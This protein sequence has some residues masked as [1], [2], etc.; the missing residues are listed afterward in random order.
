MVQALSST[1]T[2]DSEAQHEPLV[3]AA[4]HF[5]IPQKVLTTVHTYS[6]TSNETSSAHTSRHQHFDG[7]LVSNVS[8]KYPPVAAQRQPVHGESLCCTNNLVN[9]LSAHA[10]SMNT[11]DSCHVLRICQRTR[12]HTI[13]SSHHA[14]V[15]SAVGATW[16][17]FRAKGTFKQSVKL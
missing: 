11:K 10:R 5:S 16:A 17:P 6:D 12:K 3:E 4:R 9:A 1:T 8:R 14:P 7:D 13:F 15:I 2:V